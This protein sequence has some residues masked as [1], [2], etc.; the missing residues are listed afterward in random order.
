MCFEGGVDASI[1]DKLIEIAGKCPVHRTLEA[2]SAVVTRMSDE[3]TTIK[4][5]SV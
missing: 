4:T 1:A 3:Q 2:R 5:S